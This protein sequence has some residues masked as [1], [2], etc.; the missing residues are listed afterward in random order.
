ML[1]I[2]STSF[3][4]IGLVEKVTQVKVVKTKYV[5]LQNL[6]EILKDQLLSR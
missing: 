3:N 1:S 5:S 4:G 2:G 6:M